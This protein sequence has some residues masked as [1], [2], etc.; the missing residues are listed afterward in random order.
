MRVLF[1]IDEPEPL[2]TRA[3]FLRYLDELRVMGKL[4]GGVRLGT[5]HLMPPNENLSYLLPFYAMDAADYMAHIQPRGWVNGQPSVMLVGLSEA[6]PA[7]TL[8]DPYGDA[9]ADFIS[10]GGVMPRGNWW[11]FDDTGE[12]WVLE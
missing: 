10:R 9:P 11:R 7:T 3:R 8:L 5:M 2:H 1:A 6:R 4:A 12:F